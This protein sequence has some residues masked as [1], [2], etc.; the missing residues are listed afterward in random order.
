MGFF[1]GLDGLYT[2]VAWP[3]VAADELKNKPAQSALGL[4]GGVG[5]SYYFL[6][7]PMDL[8]QREQFIELGAFYLGIGVTYYAAGMIYDKVA[9]K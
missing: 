6:G 4:A 7:N 3:M 5:V 9:T 8:F 1:D 2:V